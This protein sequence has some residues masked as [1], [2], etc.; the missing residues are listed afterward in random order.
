[1]NDLQWSVKL[2]KSSTNHRLRSAQGGKKVLI[3][4]LAAL[5]ASVTIVWFGF[6]GW[7][8]IAGLRWLSN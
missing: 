2:Q 7:G 3:Y 6:L 8:L 4:F 1:M 5:M